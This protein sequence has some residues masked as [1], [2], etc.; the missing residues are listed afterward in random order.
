[1]MEARL[2]DSNVLLYPPLRSKSTKKKPRF[3]LLMDNA[4]PDPDSVKTKV[5]QCTDLFHAYEHLYRSFKFDNVKLNAKITKN[6]Q[7]TKYQKK[8]V[9]SYLVKHPQVLM[10]MADTRIKDPRIE[11]YW[12]TRPFTYNSDLAASFEMK[13]PPKSE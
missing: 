10:A 6:G 8:I 11:R 13:S 9:D 12:E 7:M 4:E 1:M 2:V 3:K 5:S